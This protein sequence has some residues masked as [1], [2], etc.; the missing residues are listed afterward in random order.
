MENAGHPEEHMKNMNIF[1]PP[2]PMEHTI[3][4]HPIH[5]DSYCSSQVDSDGWRDVL[6]YTIRLWPPEEE[7][8]AS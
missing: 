1:P 5:K 2:A 6:P 7:K 3:Q 4:D 8:K